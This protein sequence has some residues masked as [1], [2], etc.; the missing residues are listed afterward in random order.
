[1]VAYNAPKEN[2]RREGAIKPSSLLGKEVSTGDERLM[3]GRREREERNFVSE[4]EERGYV[5]C[6]AGRRWCEGEFGRRSGWV[7]TGSCT[8]LSTCQ[9]LVSRCFSVEER[10]RWSS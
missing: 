6:K 2:A 9:R 8:F 4:E 1:M 10:R 7:L 5:R 3:L